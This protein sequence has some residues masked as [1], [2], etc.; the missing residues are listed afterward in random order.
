MTKGRHGT[1]VFFTLGHAHL[2]AVTVNMIQNTCANVVTLWVAVLGYKEIEI[3]LK[4]LPI[5][6]HL[7]VNPR[8]DPCNSQIQV[9]N[10]ELECHG[11]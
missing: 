3:I 10:T 11:Q 7:D 6:F 8:T 4:I 1:V 2:A 9:E 5:L